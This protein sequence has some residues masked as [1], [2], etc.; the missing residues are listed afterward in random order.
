MWNHLHKLYHQV[1]NAR[2][3]HLETELAKYI[4]GD[5]TVQDYYNGFLTSWN[6]LD[7]TELSNVPTESVSS[8][9]KIQQNS[10]ISQSLMTLCPEFESV[11]AALVNMEVTPDLDTCVQEILREEIRL[12]SQNT[13]NEE[14]KAFVAPSSDTMALISTKEKQVQCFECKGFGHMARNCEKKTFYNY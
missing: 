14:P 11:R 3:T 10:H 9:I 2:K 8:V 7:A 6:E 12:Q 5:K 1:N 13:L 4:Q